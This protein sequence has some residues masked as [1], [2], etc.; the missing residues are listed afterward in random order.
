MT[1]KKETFY[2]YL[3]K[4]TNKTSKNF[5]PVSLLPICSKDFERIICDN[6]LKYFLDNNLM[7]SKQSGVRP[8]DS[9]VNQ[10]LSITYDINASFDNG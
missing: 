5:K 10:L 4:A 9:C 2:L 3:K 6:M 7:Y 8:G 1:G